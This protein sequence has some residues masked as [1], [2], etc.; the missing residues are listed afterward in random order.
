MRRLRLDRGSEER[1]RGGNGRRQGKG[2]R[3]GVGG[4]G[5]AE[6]GRER[7]GGGTEEEVVRKGGVGVG[8]SEMRPAPAVLERTCLYTNYADC[9]TQRKERKKANEKK[10]AHKDLWW[11]V[12]IVQ[13]P[14]FYVH[15]Y[16]ALCTLFYTVE[17]IWNQVTWNKLFLIETK[18]GW[19]SGIITACHAVDPGSIPGPRN[20]LLLCFLSL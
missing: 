14:L 17:H 15:S 5:K 9:S 6:A 11:L 18:R 10:S 13:S 3:G 19:F 8:E 7:H 20:L 12:K 4:G 16:L 2:G 1:S